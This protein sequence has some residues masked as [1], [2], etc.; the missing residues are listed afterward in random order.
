VRMARYPMIRTR[1]TYLGAAAI[2]CA[3]TLPG[4]VSAQQSNDIP[5]LR[6]GL[7]TGIV[8]NDN[9]GLDA[10]SQG[11]TVELI[12]RLDFGLTF[13]T[14]IQQLTLDGEI[15]LRKV[16]GAESDNLQNGLVNPN[17]AIGYARQSRD[18]QFSANLRINES[19]VSTSSLL[20]V[21]G[22]PDPELVTQD[23]TR[24]S[25]VFDTELELRNR[26]P[27]G[28]TLSAGYTGLRYSNVSSASLSDQDR[29]RLGARFRF[30]LTPVTQA[31]LDLRYSTFED[32]AST[33]GVRETYELD[34]GLSQDLRTGDISFLV[35]ATSTED[36]D[37]YSLSVGRS[38]RTPLWELG[39]TLGVTR[40]SNGNI[41]PTATLEVSRALVDGSL[42]ASFSRSVDSGVDDDEEQITSVSLAYDRQFT[43][44]TS[45]NASFSF[46]ETDP[47]GAAN[48][49]SLTT[50]GV[51]LQRRL[52]PNW[53]MDLG[54]EHRISK[55]T[56]G[57]RARDNLLSVMLR[58]DLSARR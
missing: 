39:G 32:L 42:Q 33:V 18:A 52:T 36:G 31:T 35:G 55:S 40:A 44:T 2:A 21:L 29:F 46:N 53:E 43:A 49:S 4:N 23:G 17:L 7:S 28:I 3:A 34:A 5:A 6:F 25:T 56:L 54:L 41:S 45:F 16:S 20:N 37:R 24:R 30:D 8:A 15:G 58:H 27:F 11:S 19:D 48:S 26:S 57:T 50:L 51:S 38:L 14:P 10:N 12:S 1:T 47:T 9:R 13:A 22:V